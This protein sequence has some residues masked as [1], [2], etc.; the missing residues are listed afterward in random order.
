MKPMNRQRDDADGPHGT[1]LVTIVMYHVIKPRQG[2]AAALKG[3][4][5]ESFCGQLNYIRKHYTPVHLFEV[6]DAAAGMRTLPPRPVVLTFDDGYAGHYDLAFPALREAAV[7]ATFFPVSTS[8]VDRRVLDVNK[9]QLVLAA[10]DPND[11]VAAIED[12]VDRGGAQTG[13]TPADYRAQGWRAS[14]WDS[15]AV[16]YIKR[17][18]QHAM[19]EEARRGLI[20]DL[21][22]RYVGDDERDVASALYMTV[23]QA[24]TM[25]RAGMTIGAHGDRHVRLPTL[26]PDQQAVEIDGALR[27]LDAIGAPRRPFVYC[28]ANGDH[29]DVSVALLRARGCCVAVTTRPDLARADSDPLTLPRLDT[30]DLPIDGDAPI[31]DWTRRAAA[32]VMP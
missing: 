5:Y 16:A 29:D 21:F 32:D 3:L 1:D 11:I 15:A 31:A 7:P 22:A 18:L 27:V 10:A 12:A 2:L 24:T 28:Y 23:D 25:H 17:M 30:N 26:T 4:D 19:P 6:A 8:T 9:I 14:R 20:D 13:K